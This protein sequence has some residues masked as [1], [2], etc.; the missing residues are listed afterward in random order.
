MNGALS[1]FFSSRSASFLPP[2]SFLQLCTIC[3]ILATL[4]YHQHPFKEGSFGTSGSWFPTFAR[5]GDDFFRIDYYFFRK[6]LFGLLGRGTAADRN[7]TM[8]YLLVKNFWRFQSTISNMKA[9][10]RVRAG[11]ISV[12]AGPRQSKKWYWSGKGGGKYIVLRS[13]GKAPEMR[14]S[15]TSAKNHA[16]PQKSDFFAMEIGEIYFS[17]FRIL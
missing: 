10:R 15:L 2:T 6:S 11:H 8:K 13:I 12:G 9:Q 14:A 4:R 16:N 17:L 3:T 7:M 1:F 5:R